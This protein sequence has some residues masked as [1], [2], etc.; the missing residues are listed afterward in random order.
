MTA[1]IYKSMIFSLA[2]LG[3]LWLIWSLFAPHA[4]Y[5]KAGFWEPIFVVLGFIVG[6]LLIIRALIELRHHKT[7]HRGEELCQ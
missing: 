3:C 4:D 6:P 7:Y 2:T 5:D 1:I